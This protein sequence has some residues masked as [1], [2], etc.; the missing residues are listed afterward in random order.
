MGGILL[1]LAFCCL[2]ASSSGFI[3]T[4]RGSLLRRK[5]EPSQVGI[6]DT[7]LSSSFFGNLG[8]FFNPKDSDDDDDND[9][10]AGTNRLITIPV[11]EV[12]PG[13]LRLFLMFYLMGMQNTPDRNSWKADQ[14]S[15]EEYQVD[16]FY[17]DRSALLSILLQEDKVT[18]DRI[19]SSPSNAYMM[20]ESVIVEGILQELDLCAFDEKVPEEDRLL[21][22]KE[23]KDAI[24]KARD[25]LAFS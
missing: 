3:S 5:S 23:P 24:E 25:A 6:R 15:T 10:A 22:L 1:V 17:H 18:I 19:G 11:K 2:A 13:G 4:P 9:S 21:I 7:A 12:K 20:Q 14:P 16:F 8:N